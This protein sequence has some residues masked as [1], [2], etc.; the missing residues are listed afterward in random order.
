LSSARSYVPVFT[1][2]GRTPKVRLFVHVGVPGCNV[3]GDPRPAQLDDLVGAVR[4]LSPEAQAYVATHLGLVPER[5]GEQLEAA[6][7]VIGALSDCQ[8]AVDKFR[9]YRERFPEQRQETEPKE[10]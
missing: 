8:L 9:L 5:V 6:E 7:D 2:H 4:A 1:P 10:L 3:W